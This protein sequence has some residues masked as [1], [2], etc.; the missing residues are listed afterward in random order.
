MR[1]MYGLLMFFIG[2]IGLILTYYLSTIS[3]QLAATTGRAPSTWVS[4]IFYIIS[5]MLIVFGMLNDRKKDE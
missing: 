4:V 2:F 5:G 1:N 3:M